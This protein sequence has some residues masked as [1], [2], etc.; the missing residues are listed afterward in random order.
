VSASS[1]SGQRRLRDCAVCGA[2]VFAR[3]HQSDSARTCKPICAKTLAVQEH[4]DI[5]KVGARD[6]GNGLNGKLAE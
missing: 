6:S 4:P 1:V 2:P 5:D 3:Q